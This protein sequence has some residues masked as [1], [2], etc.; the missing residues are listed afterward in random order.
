MVPP[1]P[2]PASPPGWV[3]GNPPSSQRYR[4]CSHVSGPRQAA[5]GRP[6]F[7][8]CV[9]VS[10]IANICCGFGVEVYGNVCP[11]R[12]TE[13]A[14]FRPVG[15]S[16]RPHPQTCQG[17]AGLDPKEGFK[18]SQNWCSSA[19]LGFSVQFLAEKTPTGCIWAAFLSALFPAALGG[20]L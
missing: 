15:R 13:E 19:S 17:V 20:G 14:L 1:G 16:G 4:G 2:L 12:Q 8:G 3:V 6:S 18:N 7:K 10:K 5:P 9:L 11:C